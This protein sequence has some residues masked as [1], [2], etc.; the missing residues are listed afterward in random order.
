M[1]FSLVIK[2][3]FKG[4]KDWGLKSCWLAY[5]FVSCTVFAFNRNLADIL[6]KWAVAA[7]VFF[8]ELYFLGRP[9]FR[10]HFHSYL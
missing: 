4:R 2:P 6:A 3:I 8:V 5:I 1:G 10:S 7:Y 9:S